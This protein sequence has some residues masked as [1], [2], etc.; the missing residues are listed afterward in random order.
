M[1]K[2][3]INMKWHGVSIC[4]NDFVFTCPRL[5]SNNEWKYG[6]FYIYDGTQW[7]MIGG[8]CTQMIKFIEANG[9][10]EQNNNTTFL[11]RQ[12]YPSSDVLNDS[13]GYVLYDANNIPLNVAEGGI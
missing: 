4:N 5:Y 9:G 7:K 1:D 10:E 3:E 6:T 12:A 2:G 8:A 11:V 13:S